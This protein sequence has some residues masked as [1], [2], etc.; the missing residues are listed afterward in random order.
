MVKSQPS[1]KRNKPSSTPSDPQQLQQQADSI[2]AQFL[3][4][5]NTVKSYSGHVD[6]GQRFCHDLKSPEI[7][8]G[9]PSVDIAAIKRDHL[10]LVT[11]LDGIPNA[12]SPE[13][14]VLFITHKC[15]QEGLGKSTADSI[16]SAFKAFWEQ[17]CVLH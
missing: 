1:Q 11:A 5:E 13:A 16:Y 3:R 14:L 12:R 9:Y 7:P 15:G 8:P 10:D 2:K 4:S 6:R 17:L